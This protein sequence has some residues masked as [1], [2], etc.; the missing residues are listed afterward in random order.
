[1]MKEFL[2][3]WGVLV[4]SVLMNAYGAFIIKLRL[5]ELGA[6]QMTTLKNASIYFFDLFKTPLAFT[7]GVLFAVSPFLFAI[8]LS[9]MEIT[10]AYPVQI[11][12]NFVIVVLLAL[13]FLGEQLTLIKCLGILFVFMGVFLLNR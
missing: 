1:M 13:F 9:R 6:F 10:V 5:N 12:L 2:L 4:A 11:G 3:S 7:A 8:A